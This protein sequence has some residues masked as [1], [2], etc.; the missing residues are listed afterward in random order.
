MQLVAL[1]AMGESFVLHAP[2]KDQRFDTSCEEVGHSS[3]LIYQLSIGLAGITSRNL[4]WWWRSRPLSAAATPLPRSAPPRQGNM[5]PSPCRGALWYPLLPPLLPPIRGVAATASGAAVVATAPSCG[6]SSA[7]NSGSRNR[8]PFSSHGLTA[9][10][11][12]SMSLYNR[13]TKGWYSARTWARHCGGI[14]PLPRARELSFFGCGGA[15]AAEA[16]VR[17]ASAGRRP[18]WSSTSP[19]TTIGLRT[20]PA[21]ETSKSCDG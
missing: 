1:R 10:P 17:A 3:S 9:M 2:R 21:N 7:S 8:V 4:P 13:S 6:G 14:C 16:T 15:P 5:S 19:S 18:A 11:R 12:S 20:M